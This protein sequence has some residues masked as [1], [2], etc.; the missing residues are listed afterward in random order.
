MYR[1]PRR[2]RRRKRAVIGKEWQPPT[3]QDVSAGKWCRACRIRHP[4]NGRDKLGIDY[5]WRNEH[6]VILWLCPRTGDVL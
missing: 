2:W 3:L 1:P 5:E 4:Y 6:V